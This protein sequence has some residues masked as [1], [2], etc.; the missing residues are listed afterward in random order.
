MLA[1]WAGAGGEAGTEE[2]ET[3]A[4]LPTHMAEEVR[5]NGTLIATETVALTE[6]PGYSGG[7]AWFLS[8]GGALAV[9]GIAPGETM[10]LQTIQ[11]DDA[12]A[13][14]VILVTRNP[15]DTL[16]AETWELQDSGSP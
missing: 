1:Q 10:P 15:D 14:T 16:T 9:D 5:A 13:E 8:G 2:P 6:A 3:E 12:P 11:A 7:K 4:A